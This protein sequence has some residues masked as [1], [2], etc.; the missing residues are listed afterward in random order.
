[1]GEETW[2]S[3][4][5]SETKKASMRR[6]HLSSPPSNAIHKEDYRTAIQYQKCVFFV[7]FLDHGDNKKR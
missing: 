3:H 4:A 5:M 7:D 6:K 1:M 2:V